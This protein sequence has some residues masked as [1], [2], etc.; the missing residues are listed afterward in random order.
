LLFVAVATG[1]IFA[2]QPGSAQGTTG[3]SSAP[4][5]LVVP[6]TMAPAMKSLGGNQPTPFPLT[7]LAPLTGETSLPFPAY[8]TPVPGVNSGTPAPG[9]SATVTLQQAQMVAFARSPALATARNDVYVEEAEVRLE[10]AGLL[11]LLSGAASYDY[12]HAQ[13]GSVPAGEAAAAAAAGTS[14]SSGESSTSAGF[15]LSLSQLIYDGGKIAAGVRAARAA[16]VSTA[17]AYR[18][19][20]QTVAYNVAAAYYTYLADERTTQVDLEIVREDV[21]Q[22]DLVRAQVRAGTAAQSD[23]ATVELPV[24]EA[25]LA[26]VQ[27]QGAELSA[28]AAFV[29]S[30]GLD[31]NS[32]VQPIDDA[33]IFTATQISSIPVP[34]YDVALQRAIALRPDYDAALQTVKQ[35]QYLVREAKLGLFPTLSAAGTASDDS[36]GTNSTAFRNSQTIGLSLSIPIYDQGVTAA[37]V[38]SARANLNNA[39]AAL[40]TTTLTVQL[41]IKQ[42]LANLVAARAALDETQVAYSTA[43]INLKATDAQ[44]RAGVTTLPLL[45]NAEVGLTQALTN[46]VTAV[47]TLRQ[48][49]QTY[50]YNVGSNYD[51]SANNGKPAITPTPGP[52]AQG[53]NVASAPPKKIAAATQ[54]Q[55]HALME[56]LVADQQ[57][58]VSAG[59]SALAAR[60]WHYLLDAFGP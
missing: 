4:T 59:N 25:R 43:L 34:T 10:Q 1:A 46:Q 35:N 16:E 21:V 31:A 57:Q 26:V 11:P 41:N 23:I 28:E 42:A 18:R 22:L 29:N 2:P 30:M 38:A 49:E 20:L 50:L 6:G 40:Q 52:S 60:K 51:T 27:A 15:S 33:P 17:D 7:T 53:G 47:Y 9:I 24:A 39:Y 3:P 32:K 37:N 54:K 13:P 56:Q 45:L 8:G 5:T 58:E 55:W 48:A 19:E 12:T 36:T 44:Y 14:V